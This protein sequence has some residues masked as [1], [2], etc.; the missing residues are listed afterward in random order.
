L[1]PPD[2]F[3]NRK[4]EDSIVIFNYENVGH[5][6]A[7]KI[8]FKVFPRKMSLQ[9]YRSIGSTKE[10]IKTLMHGEAC[11]SFGTNKEGPA[12]YPGQHS[13]FQIPFEKDLV[14]QINAPN[15]YAVVVA[16]LVYETLRETHRS[17]F[18]GIISQPPRTGKA[19]IVSWVMTPINLS[20]VNV[21][22]T[23]GEEGA[24]YPT[25]RTTARPDKHVYVKNNDQGLIE[26]V[27][28]A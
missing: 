28:A 10:I 26:A 14:E 16:C 18:C 25:E 27:A 2:N 21:A 13:A 5:E 23:T 17:R 3:R 11:D 15:G 1:V 7:T 12:I 8:N 19:C 6:P 9:E 20:L 24:P 4:N 22:P